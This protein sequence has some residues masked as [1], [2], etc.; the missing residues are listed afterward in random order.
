[1]PELLEGLCEKA[2]GLENDE[3]ISI[4][5]VKQ[6]EA[7]AHWQDMLGVLDSVAAKDCLVF[8]SVAFTCLL[9]PAYEILE[10]SS[11]NER[12]WIDRLCVSWAE[13]IRLTRRDQDVIRVLLTSISLF[14]PEK[15]HSSS[16]KY[17]LR[18]MWFREGL[19]VFTIYLESK[20][21]ALSPVLVWKKLAA[22]A[23]IAYKQE[24]LGANQIGERFRKT[25]K[26]NMM[27]RKRFF[28]SKFKNA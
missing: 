2:H 14:S 16:A 15:T 5:K 12:N 28:N 8:S 11:Q 9:L 3:E 25:K 4:E 20:K 26:P 7:F 10:K 19:L 21:Q 27:N 18:K 6:S 17:L 13:R 1:M 22:D 23:N 24:K